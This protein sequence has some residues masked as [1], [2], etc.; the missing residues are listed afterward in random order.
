MQRELQQAHEQFA[1]EQPSP[2]KRKQTE[3][4]HK[5]ADPVRKHAPAA[6]DDLRQEVRRLRAELNELRGEIKKRP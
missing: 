5:P 1:K 4:G 6:E 2:E 3:S